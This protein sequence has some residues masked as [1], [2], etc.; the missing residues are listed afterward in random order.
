MMLDYL[1]ADCGY[2]IPP[3]VIVCSDC[4]RQSLE[5][6]KDDAEPL[7][8][9]CRFRDGDVS[10][11]AA[12]DAVRELV[13]PVELQSFAPPRFGRGSGE[14]ESCDLVLAMRHETVVDRDAELCRSLTW[15]FFVLEGLVLIAA[16]AAR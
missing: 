2:V 15:W 10:A 11:G 1:P 13:V 9:L 7:C 5:I 12:R 14:I 3:T 16:A 8:S 4:G 6:E